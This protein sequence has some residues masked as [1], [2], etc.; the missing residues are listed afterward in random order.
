MGIE[1]I[2]SVKCHENVNEKSE[3]VKWN[4]IEN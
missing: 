3:S 1:Q 4:Y 2:T